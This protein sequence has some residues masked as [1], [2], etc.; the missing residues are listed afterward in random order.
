MLD[1][2]IDAHIS[3]MFRKNLVKIL[4]IEKGVAILKILKNVQKI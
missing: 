2:K 3:V 1:L 4:K